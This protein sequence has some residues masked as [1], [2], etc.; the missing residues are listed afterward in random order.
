M[1]RQERHQRLAAGKHGVLQAGRQKRAVGG[2][3]QHAGA[4]QRTHQRG[5]G[6]GPRGRVHDELAQH[7][8]VVRRDLCPLFQRMVKAQ[9]ARRSPL[10]RGGRWCAEL[11][12]AAGVGT[13]VRVFGT[14]AHFDGVALQMHLVLRERQRLASR[15]ADLPLH[16]VQPGEGFSHRVLHLQAGVHLH[17]EE[18]SPVQKEFHRARTHI[19]SGLCQRHGASAHALAQRCVHRRAGG[20]FDDLL[21]AALYRTIALAQVDACAIGVGKDLHLHM[22]RLQQCAFDEQVATAKAGQ[23]FGSGTR[24]RRRQLRQVGD[25]AHA[26][27]SPT[28]HRLDHEGC[29]DARSLGGKAFVALVVAGVP[30]QAGHAVRMGQG[31]GPR[32]VA[33]CADGGWQGAD[34]G[35]ARIDHGLGEVGVLAEEAIAGVHGIGAGGTGGGQQLVGAQVGVGAGRSAQRHRLSG[36]AHMQGVG[37]GVGIDRHRFDAHAVG[38]VN[39]PAGDFA[40]IGDEDLFHRLC[41]RGSIA[42]LHAA[43]ARAICFAMPAA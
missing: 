2:Q 24:Q 4:L 7:G 31:L 14:Q 25:Q 8:V 3:A 37:I 15:H 38:G 23:R 18:F 5:N 34:P 19:A 1:L 28:R 17:Q 33:Q 35:Q 11:Q 10:K 6:L 42:R 36:L 12:H 9:R 22:A 13:E 43:R 41:P 32:L 21:V 30:G 20:L 29:T 26:A 39:H 16:Q 27:P 40:A